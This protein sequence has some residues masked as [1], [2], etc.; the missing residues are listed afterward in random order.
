MGKLVKGGTQAVADYQKKLGVKVD[1][2]WGKNTQAAFIAQTRK[3]NPEVNIPDDYVV[4]KSMKLDG[5]KFPKQTIINPAVT[6][7]NKKPTKITPKKEKINSDGFGFNKDNKILGS[8]FTIN[9]AASLTGAAS[10]LALGGAAKFGGKLLGKAPQLL[11]NMFKG[12]KGLPQKAGGNK[13]PFKVKLPEMQKFDNKVSQPLTYRPE[14]REALT[15]SG[16]IKGLLKG[17]PKW[18]KIQE[19]KKTRG[20]LESIKPELRKFSDAT[21]TPRKTQLLLDGPINPSNLKKFAKN[22]AIQD[23]EKEGI[24][25]A[26]KLKLKQV[27]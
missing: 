13:L 16:K 11:K 9:P 2:A 7:E 3:A 6:S 17:D 4:P 18:E 19:F 10:I 1:G 24:E 15:S 26:K 12:V 5:F 20:P 25:V 27:K 21:A 23:M 8:R 14:P 22:S